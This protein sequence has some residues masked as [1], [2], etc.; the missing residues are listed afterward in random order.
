M[1]T[2]N[3][4]VDAINTLHKNSRPIQ[5]LLRKITEYQQLHP[6][7]QQ[8]STSSSS[9]NGHPSALSLPSSYVEW[10]GTMTSNKGGSAYGP[11]SRLELGLTL[12]EAGSWF[13]YVLVLASAQLLQQQLLETM[14]N[15]KNIRNDGDNSN[16]SSL[17]S[18]NIE[19]YEAE[20]IDILVTR[21]A[22]SVGILPADIIATIQENNINNTHNVYDSDY[23]SVIQQHVEDI[24]KSIVFLLQAVEA[25]QLKSL[26]SSSTPLAPPRLT[27]TDLKKVLKWNYII[28]DFF[29]YL[30]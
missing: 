8:Y 27:G 4:D 28:Y 23:N 7:E 15:N 18:F 24:Y 9:N 12:R 26:T 6:Q 30:A 17:G 25:L 5:A 16:F 2:K 22:V 19:Q 13:P 20:L 21:L 11:I 14:W 29:L 3:K 1:K 10:I